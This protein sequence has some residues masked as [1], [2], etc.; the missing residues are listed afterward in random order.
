MAL[1]AI[2]LVHYSI[3]QGLLTPAARIVLGG[4]LSISLIAGG[5]WF[6]R[7]EKHAGI[8]PAAAAHIPSVLT[9]AGTVAAFATIYAAHALYAFIGPATTFIL[10]GAVGLATMLAAALHGPALAGLGLAGSYATPL[11]VR[12]Q[13]SDPWPLVLF[14]FIVA[15]SALVLA[16][17]RAWGWLAAVTVVGALI[18]GA[19]LAAKA[20]AGFGFSGNSLDQ[21]WLEAAYSHALLQLALTAIILGVMPYLREIPSL[22]KAHAPDGQPSSIDNDDPIATACLA[23]HAVLAF[24]LLASTP[25]A[26]SLW[27]PYALAVMTLLTATAT[28][29]SP[30]AGAA[31]TA[32]A[33]SL[34]AVIAFPGA[35]VDSL[36]EWLQPYAR[37]IPFLRSPAPF[38]TFMTL[39][40]F[41]A[42]APALL[43]VAKLWRNPTIA[44]AATGFYLAAATVGPLLILVVSYLRLAAFE[45]SF[46]FMS[47]AF[48]AAGAYALFA[49]W[50]FRTEQQLSS[51][52]SVPPRGT[53]ADQPIADALSNLAARAQDNAALAT[54]G[55]AAS[56]IAALVFGIAVALDRSLLT[57]AFSLTAAGTAFIATRREIPLLR[58]VVWAIGVLVAV[59]M[60]MDPV[61]FGF[62]V[63]TTPVFNWLLVTY[64]IPALAFGAAARWLRRGREQS[65][66]AVAMC[67]GLAIVFL[68]LLAFF[69]I[70]HLTTGGDIFKPESGHVEQG[71]LALTAFGLAQLMT[72]LKRT[73]ESPVMEVA[74]TAFA[75]LSLALAMIGLGVI[76]NPYFNQDLVSGPVPFSSLFLA[77]ALPGAMALYVARLSAGIRSQR[78]VNIA[79]GVGLFLIFAYVSLEVR[80][81]FKGQQIS[82]YLGTSG[83]EMW[84]YTVAWLA[85]GIAFL[86]YGLW[87]KLTAPRLASLILIVLACLKAVFFDLA[88][89]SELWRALSFLCLGAVLIGIG[90]VYQRLIFASPNPA[91]PL[92][93]KG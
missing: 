64:G 37:P 91:E 9:A 33:L 25:V 78:F 10:L 85:L 7:G 66:V 24:I 52:I 43:S 83:A 81:G 67:E 31:L 77:Y 34:L 75:G 42:L 28:V 35:S 80:H 59:R 44:T 50:F 5:E 61:L 27:L 15:A 22:L 11:L 55:F 69:E 30:V 62:D 14:L 47:L 73:L 23:G 26:N 90:L 13:S 17:L 20:S 16:R 36:P 93:T 51:G 58:H 29:S 6:R 74:G 2:F 92:T 84:A 48:L 8:P 32:S 57:A 89:A 56:A 1:G 41:G 87:R 54:G 88:G 70:R 19:V 86:G 79:G 63:G 60:V 72:R 18:W 38:E 4:L 21:T 76:E 40:F 49:E 45:Q 53:P 71:L 82:A 39:A 68:A 65:D 3:K 12:S 46:V